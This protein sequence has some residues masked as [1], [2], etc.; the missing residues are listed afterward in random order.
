MIALLRLREIH[1][2]VVNRQTRRL[3]LRPELG[4]AG[5]RTRIVICGVGEYRYAGVIVS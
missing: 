3:L 4:R 1:G 5:P 2:S